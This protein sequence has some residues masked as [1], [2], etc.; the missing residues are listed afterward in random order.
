MVLGGGGALHGVTQL[1][2]H[3]H[4]SNLPAQ[5]LQKIL[6]RSILCLKKDL[7]MIFLA[8]KWDFLLSA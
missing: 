1:L 6:F 4:V 8:K 7:T 2:G 3:D 5:K